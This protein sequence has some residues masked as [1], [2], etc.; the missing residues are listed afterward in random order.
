MKSFTSKII[1]L[2]LVLQLKIIQNS[3]FNSLEHNVNLSEILTYTLIDLSS[4]NQYFENNSLFEDRNITKLISIEDHEQ[5]TTN[6]KPKLDASLQ[7]K[8]Q[9]LVN[10]RLKPENQN[11]EYL[12]NRYNN[13]PHNYDYYQ[14]YDGLCTVGVIFIVFLTVI[15][16]WIALTYISID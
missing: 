3:S 1:L 16:S 4:L 5:K 11:Y 10:A 14:Y 15:L 2:L 7:N 13:K 8:T 9:I 12:L 6:M